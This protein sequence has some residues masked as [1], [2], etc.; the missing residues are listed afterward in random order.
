MKLKASQDVSLFQMCDLCERKSE[1]EI[2]VKF[3]EVLP[4]VKDILSPLHE[5]KD[6]STF[7]ELWVQYGKKAQTTRKNDE[8]QKQDL[9][10]SN[11]VDNV[12]KP[13]YEAWSQLVACAWNGTL[14][15]GNVVK[16]FESYKVRKKELVQELFCIFKLD[17]SQ[18]SSDTIQ[19]KAI[20]E[21]RAAQI[22][23]YQQLGQYASAAD[24]IWE[25]KEAM[26]FTGDFTIVEDLRNQV[27]IVF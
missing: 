21:K 13:A 27:S 4:V 20:A 10:I 26:S 12:W 9:S 18:T 23:L 22:Q 5:V 14:T 17:Q 8:A 6:S 24:T 7:Q 25:F 16:F 1:N 2:E 15:L 3:F 19:L 11:V